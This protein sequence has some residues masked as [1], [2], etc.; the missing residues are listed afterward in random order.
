[1]ALKGVYEITGIVDNPVHITLMLCIIMVC[2]AHKNMKVA[3]NKVFKDS[4]S[5]RMGKGKYPLKI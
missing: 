3:T 4:Y 5:S 1:M 2:L